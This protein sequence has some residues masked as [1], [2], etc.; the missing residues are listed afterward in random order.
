[1]NKLIIAIDGFAATGKSTQAKRLAKALD[2]TYVDTGAMYRAV[3]LFALEQ[4]PKGSVDLE[5]LC[6]S[7]DQIKIHFEGSAGKQQTFLNGVNVSQAI[8]DPKINEYVSKVAA[9]EAVR[10]DGRERRGGFQK[11]EREVQVEFQLG[12][13]QRRR[14]RRRRDRSTQN[15]EAEHVHGAR[16]A[17]G[18]GAERAR[19]CI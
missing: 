7:L 14:G 12:R 6:R 17:L 11:E 9:Q 1:M 2:Y 10:R 19:R 5:L 13:A 4:E 16:G 8:R 18:H 3:T 15:A